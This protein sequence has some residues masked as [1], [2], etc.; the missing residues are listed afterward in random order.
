M[1]DKGVYTVLFAIALGILTEISRSVRISHRVFRC[2]VRLRLGV[3]ADRLV[4]S[5]SARLP[6]FAYYGLAGLTDVL[7][8]C[9]FSPFVDEFDPA[10]PA[11]HARVHWISSFS[12]DGD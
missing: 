11:S 3:L 9:L 10:S 2:D 5:P 6:T 7:G 1:I 4:P 12:I 8:E